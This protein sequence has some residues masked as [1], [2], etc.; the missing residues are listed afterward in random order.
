[1]ETEKPW[2][3]NDLTLA[4]LASRAGLSPHH[5]SQVLNDTIG[6]TFFDFVNGFRVREVQRCLADPAYSGQGV[7]AIAMAAGF[8]SKAAFNA[9]FRRHAGMTPSQYRH[10]S[11]TSAPIG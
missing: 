10:Q 8:N 5:L 7:L 1:M 9:A 4:D 11:Q 6:R 2:L 3:E